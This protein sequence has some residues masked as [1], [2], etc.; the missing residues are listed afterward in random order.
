MTHGK[1]TFRFTVAF[2]ALLA[3]A[4]S[5]G[6]S[7]VG[8]PATVVGCVDNSQNAAVQD[9]QVYLLPRLFNPSLAS[10]DS[11]FDTVGAPMVYV[12]DSTAFATKT[13]SNGAFAI[14]NVPQNAYTLFVRDDSGKVAIKR[15]IQ[16]NT[17]RVD[18]GRET[19]KQPGVAIIDIADNAFSPGGY[20]IVAGTPLNLKVA[21]PGQY[22]MR[23][24]DDTVTV[25][26]ILGT[27]DNTPS[28][29]IPHSI[30]VTPGDTVDM[31]GIP[32][33]VINGS[34][35]YSLGGPALPLTAA[36]TI[37]TADSTV[38]FAVTGAY[39]NKGNALAYQFFLFHDSS[40]TILTTWNASAA[41]DAHLSTFGWYYVSCR[42]QCTSPAG[43]VVSEWLPTCAVMILNLGAGS[44]SAPRV[45][46]LVDTATNTDTLRAQFSTG[47]AVSSRGDAAWYRFQ[48]QVDTTGMSMTSWSPDSI[49]Y[50]KFTPKPRFLYVGSQARSSFDTT[51]VSSW[52]SFTDTLHFN[53]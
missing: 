8:N 14:H 49:T 32:A 2:A 53:Y 30:S 28:T 17:G 50:L 15:N 23:L 18:L 41:Y 47:G 34:L 7:Q 4:C 13:D 12:D 21:A 29:S 9:A 46:I 51:Q 22:L 43:Q 11:A 48:I 31:T 33:F 6:G 37:K 19:V 42:A 40:N 44:V 45:P 10:L 5:M 27:K 38:R 3:C 39:S 52:S 20:L 1:K 26:Y 16:I 35:G 25:S 24:P 36:D